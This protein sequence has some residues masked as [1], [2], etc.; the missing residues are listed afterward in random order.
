MGSKPCSL[1][2]GFVGFVRWQHLLPAPARF[3][4][5]LLV[6]VWKRRRKRFVGCGGTVAGD[7]GQDR[8]GGSSS[9]CHVPVSPGEGQ[10]EA[11][12]AGARRWAEPAVGSGDSGVTWGCRGDVP[13]AAARALASAHVFG[14][15]AWLSRHTCPRWAVP[16]AWAG[17]HRAWGCAG[18]QC[19]GLWEGVPAPRPPGSRLPLPIHSQTQRCS[20]MVHGAP[21]P[22]AEH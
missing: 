5:G 1:F 2:H 16:A 10:G 22:P 20:C 9:W 3:P 7:R 17:V 11:A 15:A 12:A 13:T 6:P 21:Q 19:W 8:P 14:E 4:W 18:S